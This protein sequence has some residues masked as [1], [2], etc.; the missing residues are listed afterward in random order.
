M[1]SLGFRQSDVFLKP[2]EAGICIAESLTTRHRLIFNKFPA[3]KHHVLVITKEPEKQQSRLNR[4]DFEAVLL[5]MKTLDEAFM[6]YNAGEIAGASQEH[7][8]MQVIPVSSLQN[9]KIPI[10]DR[11]MDA[12]QRAQIGNEPES[13]LFDGRPEQGKES[14]DFGMYNNLGAL[15]SG[16]NVSSK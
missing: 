4:A 11:V 1:T 15:V 10:H 3:R 13:D 8:H 2:F 14:E 6:Y 5:A 16:Y 9:G 7:K 12:L